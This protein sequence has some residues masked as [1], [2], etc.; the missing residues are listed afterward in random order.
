MELTQTEIDFLLTQLKTQLE[1][2]MDKEF[3]TEERAENSEFKWAY[4][5]GSPS[6]PRR[7]Y[8][9]SDDPQLVHRIHMYLLGKG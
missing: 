7:V 4:Y 2:S 3:T 6:N 5:I 8:I 9:A 1:V